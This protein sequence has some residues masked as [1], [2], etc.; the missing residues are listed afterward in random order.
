MI[1][2]A[3]LTHVNFRLWMNHICQTWLHC[4]NI[5]LSPAENYYTPVLSRASASILFLKRCQS[6]ER[7][8]WGNYWIMVVGRNEEWTVKT[9]SRSHKSGLDCS[10]SWIKTKHHFTIT[11]L[12]WKFKI[13]RGRKKKKKKQEVDQP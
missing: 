7:S 1:F 12:H 9:L 6:F 8:C 3:F 10:E 13:R 4:L 2:W 5:W 11:T